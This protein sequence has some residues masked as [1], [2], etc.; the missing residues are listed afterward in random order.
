VCA[1]FLAAAG[2]LHAQSGTPLAGEAL[3][4]QTR[5]VS[6]Q[7]RCPVCQGESIQDSPADLAVEMKAVVRD[8]LAAG[9]TPDEVKAYFVARYGEWILLAPP[10]RGFNLLLYVLPFVLFVGGGAGLF[11]AARRW[12]RRPGRAAQVP[13]YVGVDEDEY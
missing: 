2:T 5:A 9:H 11:I 10:A 3:E 7:L 8:Q 6:S 4:A 1:L 12:Q 13:A